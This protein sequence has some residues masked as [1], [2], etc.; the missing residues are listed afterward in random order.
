MAVLYSVIPK[1]HQQAHAGVV[2][3]KKI[4]PH[5]VL[6]PSAYKEK[7]IVRFYSRG[8]CSLKLWNPSQYSWIVQPDE[9]LY[10]GRITCRHG[11]QAALELYHASRYQKNRDSKMN[12]HT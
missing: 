11:R 5:V 3:I 2:S 8:F 4:H 10:G 12:I 6:V 9:D 1:A 7:I